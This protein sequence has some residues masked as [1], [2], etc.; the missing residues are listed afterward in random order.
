MTQINTE[1]EVT[2]GIMSYINKLDLNYPRF[3]VPDCISHV[4]VDEVLNS[5][6]LVLN[7]DTFD[8]V[9]SCLASGDI[10]ALTSTCKSYRHFYARIWRHIALRWD[11]MGKIA[12]PIAMRNAIA[13]DQYYAIYREEKHNF[14]HIKSCEDQIK[15]LLLEND[16]MTPQSVH[17]D[18]YHS[19]NRAEIESLQRCRKAIVASSFNRRTQR[20]VSNYAFLYKTIDGVPLYTDIQGFD[21]MI[22]GSEFKDD[23]VLKKWVTGE[24]NT[25]VDYGID[26]FDVDAKDS[27]WDCDFEDEDDD[28][29]PQRTRIMPGYIK[30]ILHIW[31]NCICRDC[32]QLCDDKVCQIH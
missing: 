10:I 8:L 4:I 14:E 1:Q 22:Y 6:R 5:R 2:A 25:D 13:A 32:I 20:L 19:I 23:E 12:D 18:L 30:K 31:C 28:G 11:Y 24:Y 21:A 7:R 3:K 9:A 26:A 16:K 29:E 27:D 15:K 17:G